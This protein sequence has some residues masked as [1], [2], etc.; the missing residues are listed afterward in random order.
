MHVVCSANETLSDIAAE[1]AREK[2]KGNTITLYIS[3]KLAFNVR[4][5]KNDLQNKEGFHF[6]MWHGS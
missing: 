6:L 4:E 5:A 2:K 3:R 1:K